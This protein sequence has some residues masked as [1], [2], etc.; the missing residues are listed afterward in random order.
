MGQ[1]AE[2]GEGEAEAAE[3]GQE[4]EHMA[5]LD[6]DPDAQ[7]Q[8]SGHRRNRCERCQKLHARHYSPIH[9]ED[10]PD[11]WRRASRQRVCMKGFSQFGVLAGDEAQGFGQVVFAH[12]GL[13]VGE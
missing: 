3:G 4:Q 13:K 6:Q 2:L 5:F 12:V 7:A 8:Q 9:A 11:S 10:K 1:A